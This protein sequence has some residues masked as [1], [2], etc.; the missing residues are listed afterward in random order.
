MGALRHSLS[1]TTPKKRPSRAGSERQFQDNYGRDPDLPSEKLRRRCDYRKKRPAHTPLFFGMLADLHRLTVPTGRSE[2]LMILHIN[3]ESYGKFVEPGEAYHKST[4]PLDLND[5]AQCCG[6]DLRTI[7]RLVNDLDVPTPEN[8]QGRGLF[9]A[10]RGGKGKVSFTL[11]IEDWQKLPDY[12]EWLA[13][14]APKPVAEAE[15]ADTQG[16]VRLCKKPQTIK[17]G[18]SKSLKVPCEVTDFEFRNPLAIDLEIDP[19]VQG[20]R[21]LV[22]PRVADE[23]AQKKSGFSNAFNELT[24]ST[25][26]PVS[27]SCEGIPANGGRKESETHPRSAEVVSVFEPLLRKSGARLIAGDAKSL[28]AACVALGD[29]P[30]EDLLHCLMTGPDPRAARPISSPKH[31]A[32]I[33]REMKQNWERRGS[34]P[35]VTLPKTGKR[36]S[37]Q[38]IMDLMAQKIARDGKI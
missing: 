37:V 28:E 29:M 20:G 2:V 31:V 23:S 8:P 6:T 5:I 10:K 7:Q 34:I 15:D 19:V 25:A 36:D 16:T 38:E 17:P 9:R 30:K 11:L 26:T 18:A 27:R 24:H 33:I 32:P 4:S 13:L 3:A 35:D 1:E 21:L 14:H 12:S 22:V